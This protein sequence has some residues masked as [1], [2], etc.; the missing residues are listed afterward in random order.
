MHLY[1]C[2]DGAVVPLGGVCII[3]HFIRSRVECV[4]DIPIEV[5]R[6]RA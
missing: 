4:N 6:V 3:L 1:V 2:I 5:Y